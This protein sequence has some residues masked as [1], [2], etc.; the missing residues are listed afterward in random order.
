MFGRRRYGKPDQNQQ[1]MVD[2]VRKRLGAAVVITTGVG[3]GFVDLVVGWR[4]L[5]ILVEVKKPGG[6]LQQNQVDFRDT[7]PGG[8]IIAVQSAEELVAGL[9]MLDRE[10]GGRRIDRNLVALLSACYEQL[11]KEGVPGA[12]HDDLVRL[13]AEVRKCLT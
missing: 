8:P 4:K 10:H 1:P 13:L 5:T 11:D 7:W 9:I 6:K 2:L 12:T 3:D